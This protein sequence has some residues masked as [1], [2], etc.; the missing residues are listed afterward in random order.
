MKTQ[1]FALVGIFLAVLLLPASAH[2]CCHVQLP[3]DTTPNYVV[4]G[5]FAI[6]KNATRFTT[7]ANQL[8]DQLGVKAE[9]MLNPNRNLYYVYVL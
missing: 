3:A 8:S 9:Y 1:F 5:A 2:N 6:H 4:I 7:K